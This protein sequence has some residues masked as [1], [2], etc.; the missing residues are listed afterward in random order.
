MLGRIGWWVLAAA[1]LMAA[2]TATWTASA[3]GQARGSGDE[4]RIGHFASMTGGTAV[5]GNSADEGIRLAAEE[6]NA[7]GGVLGRPV[8]IITEDT[9]SKQEEA[10]TAVQKLINQNRVV[11]LLGEI[12]SSRSLAAAPVAQRARIPMLSPASTNPR[13]TQVGDFIFRACFIDPFQGTAMADF[14]MKSDKGPKARRF[15]ILYDVKNDYSL[16]LREFFAARVRELGG[17]IVADESYGEGDV[18]FRAQLNKIRAA[19]PDAIWIPGYYQ[20]V[21]LIARQARELGITVPLLGGDGWDAETLGQIAGEAID[22]SF[23][24]NH[25][26]A[27]DESEA[28][29]SF[30]RRYRERYNGKL[31]DAM[32]ILGYDSMMLLADAIQ[33]AGSTNGRAIRDALASTRDFP[34]AAGKITIDENRNAKKPLVVLRVSVKNVGG[35]VQQ[36]FEYVDTVNP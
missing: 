30:I 4:I 8:R 5:F 9:Q 14:A 23:F 19:N 31:P 28:V 26:S 10:V 21:G 6:I 36:R 1:G 33:R 7:R 13:V 11:A 17:T 18:D 2:A 25:F 29:Q 3:F 20:E 34:G 32:A 15:A 16:G 35:Q 24:S 12:A 22:G 27:D